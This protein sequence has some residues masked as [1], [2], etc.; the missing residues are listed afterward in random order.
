MPLKSVVWHWPTSSSFCFYHSS[1]HN[2]LPHC[3]SKTSR[4]VP[5]G[6]EPPKPWSKII[7]LSLEV[8]CPQVFCSES[9][10][11][12]IISLFYDGYHKCSNVSLFYSWTEPFPCLYTQAHTHKIFLLANQLNFQPMSMPPMQ[13][14]S[15]RDWCRQLCFILFE[16]WPPTFP[17]RKITE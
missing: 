9:W 3:E 17:E 2:A 12:H 14:R 16:I 7:L 1:C 4:S 11:K 6:L 15:H 5:H 13:E 10:I 8:G